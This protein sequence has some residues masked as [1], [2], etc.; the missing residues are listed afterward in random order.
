MTAT[1]LAATRINQA[2]SATEKGLGNQ[3]MIVAPT[4][5]GG[6]HI[7][8]QVPAAVQHLPANVVSDVSSDFSTM[9]AGGFHPEQVVAGTFSRARQA[10]GNA[11][12]RTNT[13]PPPGTGSNVGGGIRAAAARLAQSLR[14]P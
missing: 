8:V 13:S 3:P 7:P 12:V 4:T 11:L 10:V 6:A 1:N 5:V 9:L 14:R 2:S